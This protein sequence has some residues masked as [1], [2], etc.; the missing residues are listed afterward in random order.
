[1]RAQGNPS[2]WLLGFRCLLEGEGEG[3]KQ[4]SCPTWPSFSMG[5]RCSGQ[6]NQLGQATWDQIT[7]EQS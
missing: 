7:Q 5:M 4:G 6:G 3:P 1:M 2:T